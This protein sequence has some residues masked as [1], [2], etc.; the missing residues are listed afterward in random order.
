MAT[1]TDTETVD[2][3]TTHNNILERAFQTARYNEIVTVTLEDG[4][5]EV[6][7]VPCLDET[8]GNVQWNP[9]P[10][11]DTNSSSVDD[12]GSDNNESFRIGVRRHLQTKRWIF[13]MLNDTVR[14]D[15]YQKAIDRAVTYLSGSQSEDTV[16]HVWD[17]GTGTGLLGMMAATAIRKNDRPDTD[18]QRSRDGGVKV[19]R[20]FEMSAPM[21]MV[22]RQTV[23]DNHLA[24]RV[25]VHNAH[26]A[27]IAPLHATRDATDRMP[28]GDDNDDVS[29]RTPSV[30]LCVSELLEDGLLGEG[31]LP[32]I[33]DVWNRH[34]SP[35]SHHHCHHHMK[36]AI[37]IPQQARVYAQAVTADNDWIS[38][39][40]PPTRQH[41]NATSMSLT[42]DA[43]GTSL[44]DMPVVRIPLHART[45]LHTPVDPNDCT[46]RPPALR[47][48]SDPFKALDISVQRDIMP[49]PEGQA[50]T[51]SVPVTHSG[52]VYGFLVWWELD[53]WTAHDNDDDTLTYSTSP[54]TGMAWQDHWHVVLHVLRDTP[55]VQKGETMTVQASH[56]DTAITL[57][58]II[59]APAPPPS[60]RIRTEPN[61]GHHA[62][63]TPSRALQ[64]NDTARASFLDQAI[65]HALCVKGPDQLV[66]D[67]SDFSWCAIVAARQGATQVVSL[68]ASSSNTSLPHTTAR[69]AQLGNQLP[70][71]PH[72]RFEILQAHAEQLTISTLGDVPA[73]IV[74]AEPYYELL[75]NWHLEEAINYYNLVRALRR[76]KLITP[77]ACV[78]PSI[79]RV[80]GCAIQSDQ[81]R[82]AYRACGDEKGKI[83]GL[84]H[85]YVNAI[86]ADFH[87]Y[88]L[89]LPMWQYEYQMLSAPCVLATLDYRSPG[90]GPVR[91]EAQMPF[92]A[93]GRCD[94]LLIWVEYSAVADCTLRYTTNNHFHHQAVRM[95][96]TSWIVDPSEM[97][98]TAL[99]CQSQIG[100]LDPFNCHSFEVQIA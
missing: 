22:A 68:E 84:D 64:L 52:T 70:R 30:L 5:T 43:Q 1:T 14:N 45:L 25:H 23:R 86:G 26:S 94:A 66:L 37:T 92:T 74:V 38:M 28:G 32:A 36:K 93:K 46:R 75:E 85:Q 3:S 91:G 69:V 76:T 99:I 16:W 41:G 39:Y 7:L 89:N 20:A 78:I 8:N 98:K 72:S 60:K 42:L 65:T 48:L 81:L 47:V 57:L 97:S 73:D 12:D 21:A 11:P 79:C 71:A 95:L 2:D 4:V 54:H 6:S 62:L 34:W 10:L 50:C 63:I 96:P 53:L 44:V 18:V 19:V 58:P 59:S 87:Q 15:L 31:W 33:R 29:T 55:K 67:V 82:S 51:L 40:Y 80:M 90:N 35:Q 27:Q 100:G 13:P 24:D 49:G 56:D 83:H 88:N 9:L 77:D 61:S 17:V